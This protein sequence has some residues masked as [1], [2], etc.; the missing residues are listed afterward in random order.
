VPSLDEQGVDKHLADRARKAARLSDEVFE[1]VV[2]KVIKI[3][4]ATCE[5]VEAVINRR[6]AGRLAAL[7]RHAAA[8][9]VGR[10]EIAFLQLGAGSADEAGAEHGMGRQR[11]RD[12][13]QERVA[14]FDCDRPRGGH[15]G[16]EFGVGQL[17]GRHGRSLG[18]VK[19]K[20]AQ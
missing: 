10:V 17:D 13:R 11:L 6:G 15:H 14:A 19:Q 20:P 8:A 16:V 2:A 9:E 1:R 7:R 4:V 12:V 5:N 3:A 18:C